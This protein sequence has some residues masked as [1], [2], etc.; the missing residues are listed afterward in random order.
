MA[1][2]LSWL[3]AVV[4]YSQLLLDQIKSLA[5]RA[6]Q[7]GRLPAFAK[8]L[9]SLQQALEQRPLPPSDHPDTFGEPRFPLKHLGLLSCGAAIAPIAVHFSVSLEPQDTGKERFIGVYVTKVELMD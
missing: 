4:I 8:A 9:V 2:W 5:Q 1:P 6:D 7:Q 3:R